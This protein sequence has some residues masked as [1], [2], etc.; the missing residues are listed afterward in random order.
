MCLK[1]DVEGFLFLP[2]GI[3]GIKDFRIEDKKVR[4]RFVDMEYEIN[5]PGYVALNNKMQLIEMSVYDIRGSSYVAPIKERR[6]GYHIWPITRL[7]NP[8]A[9][10]M[11]CFVSTQVRYVQEVGSHIVCETFKILSKEESVKISRELLGIIPTEV[12]SVIVSNN[13]RIWKI[14]RGEQDE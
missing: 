11:P 4:A 10:I 6:L 8:N 13:E 1:V 3:I 5:E 7:Y 9:L 2:Y 14:I 12:L